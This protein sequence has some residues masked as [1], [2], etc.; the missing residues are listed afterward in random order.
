MT[1]ARAWS[2]RV[3]ASV[4]VALG[5]VVACNGGP[6]LERA[7]RAPIGAVPASVSP[8]ASPS[9]SAPGSAERLKEDHAVHVTYAAV[10][11]FVG[12]PWSEA[13]GAF[14]EE[15]T[16]ATTHRCRMLVTDALGKKPDDLAALARVQAIEP[17]VV[18]AVVRVIE[19]AA[20]PEDRA[21]LVALVPAVADA[22][23][24]ANAARRA[25]TAVRDAKDA[26]AAIAAGEAALVAKDGLARLWGLPSGP[27]R[28][29]GLV[30]AADHLESSRALPPRAKVLAASPM[31][32]VLFSL[33]RPATADAAWLPYLQ[34]AAKAAGHAPAAGDE[35][36]AFVAVALGIADRFAALAKKL[37]LGEP[38]EAA[39][40][41][42]QR[43]RAEIATAAKKK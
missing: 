6:H 11:C 32:S 20:R 43:L 8:S 38:R 10:G 42:E 22:A 39:L 18:D 26:D 34:Q 25:A 9:A 35:K 13:L 31:F 16:L 3:A 7:A 23:R 2:R 41:Y 4:A 37:P 33:A 29:V 15:R 5:A 19:K 27:A 12:G 28:A 17:E 30:I 14:G 24:E 36:A 40:G 21:E 1:I